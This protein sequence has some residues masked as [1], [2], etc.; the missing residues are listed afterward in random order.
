[1]NKM[2]KEKWSFKKMHLNRRAELTFVISNCIH[3]D[4]IEYS[5]LYMFYFLRTSSFYSHGIL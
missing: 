4:L 2:I 5:S 1:M 3:S